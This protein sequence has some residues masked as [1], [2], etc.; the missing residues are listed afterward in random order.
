MVEQCLDELVHGSTENQCN[1]GQTY[2]IEDIYYYI[3]LFYHIWWSDAQTSWCMAQ[4]RIQRAWSWD[5]PQLPG[6]VYMYQY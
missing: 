1:N 5:F 2:F 4:P 3:I 6:T